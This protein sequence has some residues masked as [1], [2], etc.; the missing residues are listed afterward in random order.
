[1]GLHLTD[2]I[3]ILAHLAVNL[4]LTSLWVYV[5]MSVC[6]GWGDSGLNSWAVTKV[7]LWS[8]FH[9]LDL[10][11]WKVKMEVISCS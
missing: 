5:H 2:I 9:W 4:S 1:M 11:F 7:Q 8:P 3:I 6:V 10:V